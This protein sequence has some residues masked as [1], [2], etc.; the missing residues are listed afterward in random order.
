MP[1]PQ[2][3]V[4]PISRDDVASACKAHT[5]LQSWKTVDA[6]L[7][8]VATQLPEFSLPATLAKVTLVNA[9]YYTNVFAV[10]RVAAHFA[11]LLKREDREAWSPEFVEQLAKVQLGSGGK[12]KRLISLASKFAHFFMDAKKFPIYDDCA[13]QAILLHLP[14][15][16]SELISSYSAYCQAF[17]QLAHAGGVPD[18]PRRLDRYLWM[19]GQYEE[20][21][22]RGKASNGEL[23]ALFRSK[24]WKPR[25]S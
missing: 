8:L 22:K 2:R 13:R 1:R 7:C 24:Q 23:D 12:V 14:V 5:S 16:R 21:K 25:S 18:E 11:E 4:V 15:R 19:R 20:F 3:N 9:L 6:T 17:S 10:A